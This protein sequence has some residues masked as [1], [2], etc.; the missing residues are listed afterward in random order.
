MKHSWEFSS[1]LTRFLQRRREEISNSAVS[2][3]VCAYSSRRLVSSLGYDSLVTPSW[4]TTIHFLVILETCLGGAMTSFSRFLPCIWSPII[5]SSS[6][7]SPRICVPEAMDLDE[8]SSD[9]SLKNP[10]RIV[11]QNG[12]YLKIGLNWWYNVRIYVIGE[13]SK[14]PMHKLYIADCLWLSCVSGPFHELTS[15]WKAQLY[16]K[17]NRL[18]R[19]EEAD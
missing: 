14:L 3:S 2:I 6:A 9:E 18:M 10:Q 5:L 17:S 15:C 16:R 7:G 13:S 1:L 8:M 4:H 19:R 12:N 11:S